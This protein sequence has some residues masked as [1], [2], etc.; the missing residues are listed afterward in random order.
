MVWGE[1]GELLVHTVRLEVLPHALRAGPPA[2]LLDLIACK[3][4]LHV[5]SCCAAV[6]QPVEFAVCQLNVVNLESARDSLS[7]SRRGKV[8]EFVSR[9]GALFTP[10][11]L[12]SSHQFSYKRIS[13]IDRFV[14]A[15][16]RLGKGKHGKVV[17]GRALRNV[18]EDKA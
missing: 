5:V 18:K 11:H 4:T 6:A 13:N 2:A 8:K 1:V 10:D 9:A 14:S 7:Q 12:L 3:T 15:T 16:L 17:I